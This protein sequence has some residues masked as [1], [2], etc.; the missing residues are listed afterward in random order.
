MIWTT[1]L[2]SF[3]LER[4]PATNNPTLRAW[5]AADDLVI[6]HL[7]GD[8]NVTGDIEVVPTDLSG[9]ILVVNDAH[10]ALACA[11]A[12]RDITS[13]TDSHLSELAARG[14]LDRNGLDA[15]SVR[16]VA[17]TDTPEGPF[18][19]V[20]VKVPKHLGLLEWQLARIAPVA[21]S[22]TKIIGAAMTRHL[23]NSTLD[24]FSSMLGPTRTS[25][26]A[27]KARLVHT[28]H[29]SGAAAA[30]SAA[31]T[32]FR[33]DGG[34]TVVNYPGV[35]SAKKL[36]LGTRTMLEHLPVF[37][38]SPDVIDLGCGN[39]VL[40]T[41]IAAA[42]PDASVTFVDESHLAVAAAR[43]TYLATIGDDE[44][45]TFAVGDALSSWRDGAVPADES[46]DIVVNNPPF[47]DDHALSDATAWQMFGDAH[48]VLRGGGEL[49]VVGNQHLKLHLK[50]Q[51]R[52]GNCEVIGSNPKFVV[53]RAVKGPAGS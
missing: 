34:V 18:D 25:R 28:L 37:P 45:A 4:H 9:R 31:T 6:A 1:G 17:A 19:L 14:N 43:A 52:F 50:L 53:L 16:F 10:G 21:D 36:D 30:P 42:N 22:D 27:K 15:E 40:G 11:F 51:R 20:I 2:G 33:T 32:T 23:H 48:R 47:H 7:L 8:E 46:V 38:G 41:T 26:A 12:D 13:W 44:Q 3:D 35:F 49:W 39:G 24:L 29:P 5:N